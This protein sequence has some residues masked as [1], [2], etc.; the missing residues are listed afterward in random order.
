[1]GLEPTALC[2]GRAS[3]R[4]PG[5]FSESGDAPLASRSRRSS[6]FQSAPLQRNWGE[7][8]L[9][10]WQV[11]GTTDDD[12]SGLALLPLLAR[13]VSRGL[14]GLAMSSKDIRENADAAHDRPLK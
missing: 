13:P 4:S 6:D 9:I 5:A 10:H 3:I 8:K 1:M 7:F 2:L 14:K 12:E 11:E